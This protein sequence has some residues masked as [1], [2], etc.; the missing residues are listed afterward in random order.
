MDKKA[1]RE[2]ARK[3]LIEKWE[4]EPSP[5]PL[6]RGMTPREV[7]RVLLRPKPSPPHPAPE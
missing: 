2:K 6:A 3:A 4:N 1:E 5:N 7:A